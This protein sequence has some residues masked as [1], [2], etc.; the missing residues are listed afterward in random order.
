MKDRQTID[1]VFAFF[2]AITLAAMFS[3]FVFLLVKSDRYDKL[4]NNVDFASCVYAQDFDSFN[5]SYNEELEAWQAKIV[6]GDDLRS[7]T[8]S[9]ENTVKAIV[10]KT[11]CK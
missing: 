1:G 6:K 7:I 8:W 10:L 2:I 4:V 11:Y 5:F 9:D 3:L